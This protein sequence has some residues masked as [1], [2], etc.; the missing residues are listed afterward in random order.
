MP[1]RRKRNRL[2]R[3]LAVFGPALIVLLTGMLSYGAVHRTLDTRGWVEHTR[4]VLDATD[5]LRTALLEGETGERGFLLTHDSTFLAPYSG[6]PVRAHLAFD[7]LRFL[8]RDNPVQQ[9]RLDTLRNL[10][11]RRFVLL[12]SMIQIE[13]LGESQGAR[14]FIA[15]GPGRSHMIAIRE[16]IDSVNVEESRLLSVRRSREERAIDLATFVILLGTLIAAALAFLVNRRFD[17]ALIDRRLALTD[18]QSANDKLQEQA[19]ELEH[20]AESSQNVALE[21]EQASEQAQGALHLAEESE[22]RADRLQ[23]ATE[24]FTGALSLGEV[25][26]LIVDQAMLAVGAHSAA[27]A[28]YEE[29]KR[30]LR[31]IAVSNVSIVKVG[32]VISVD[33]ARPMCAAVRDGQPVI[34]GSLEDTRRKFG[35]IAADHQQDAVEAFAAYP[36]QNNGATIGAIIVRFNHPRTLTPADRALL[37]AMSRIA[38][39]AFERARLY[40]AERAARFAA[41]GANRAK[42]AFLASMSHELRTPL[43]A[44]L[45]FAQ[46]VRSEVYGPINEAQ[47]EVLGRIERSQTHLARL[48]DDIL[49][50][51]RLE[52]GRVRMSVEDV[53]VSD[54][55]ADLTPL[56]EPQAVAKKIELSLLPPPD[57][58]RVAADRH[59]LRQILVNIVGNAIKFTPE[60]GTIRVGALVDGSKAMIQVRDTG[61]GIPADRLQAIFEPF[62]QVEDGLTRTASGA[63]LGLAISRDLARAMGGDLTVESQIGMGSTF[64]VWLPLVAHGDGSNGNGSSGA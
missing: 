46:L 59:R 1:D 18:L 63:G 47:G 20:Q 42:A 9:R 39:E 38:A 33:E 16:I 2:V 3:R 43:Q 26:T 45:G 27:L 50:F 32:D 52:A 51:A 4:D 24:A 44:A 12:D 17:A 40:E 54:V 37:G 34:S 7:R 21:A 23:M 53:L 35:A 8:T 11:D 29:E 19:I 31:F 55:I 61:I 22:R 41:E 48:I 25:S 14:E 36:M 58:F 62:V 56:V 57:S 60:T 28:S 64:T 5:Q 6:T 30:Q 49:D 13:R 15:F 10:V